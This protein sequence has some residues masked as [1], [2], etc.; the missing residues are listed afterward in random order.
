MGRGWAINR[1]WLVYCIL[2]RGQRNIKSTFSLIR[3]AT[4]QPHYHIAKKAT[5]PTQWILNVWTVCVSIGGRGWTTVV[6]KWP[7]CRMSSRCSHRWCH[8]I[9][10]RREG[11]GQKV[12]LKFT[13]NR[14]SKCWAVQKEFNVQGAPKNK[15]VAK[16][17]LQSLGQIFIKAPFTFNMSMQ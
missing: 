8:N 5:G 12:H 4:Q 6:F 10:Y 16:V 15:T 13:E 1:R 2:S 9:S 14:V 3:N 17:P 7:S 11:D